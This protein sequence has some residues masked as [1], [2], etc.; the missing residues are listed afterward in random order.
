METSPTKYTKTDL[1]RLAS[2]FIEY[3][4][5]GV[6]VRVNIIKSFLKR[7]DVKRIADFTDDQINEAYEG[8]TILISRIKTITYTT[9]KALVNVN[10]LD[11][12][13]KGV[14]VNVYTFHIDKWIKAYRLIS[15]LKPNKHHIWHFASES[16]SACPL[17]GMLKRTKRRGLTLC[18][19]EYIIGNIIYESE[20]ICS[21]PSE[22]DIIYEK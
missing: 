18:Y 7:Y 15:P 10:I 17:C 19:P 16:A 1:R 12:L 20:G 11:M 3:G 6:G 22:I 4:N 5:P 14:N 21:S 9:N 2:D 13:S 8:L